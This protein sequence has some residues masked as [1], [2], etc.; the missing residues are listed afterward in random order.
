MPSTSL[1]CDD[2]EE[3]F[4]YGGYN[5]RCYVAKLGRS[6]VFASVNPSPAIFAARFRFRSRSGRQPTRVLDFKLRR[7]ERGS[8]ADIA[9]VPSTT[10]DGIGRRAEAILA[11]VEALG[12]ARLV[13]VVASEVVHL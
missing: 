13:V 10:H 4:K 9:E 5:D 3:G 11:E 2:G 6:A 1:R 12:L 8:G 7:E